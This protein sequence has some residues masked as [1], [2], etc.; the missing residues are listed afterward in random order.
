M[1]MFIRIF[2][3]CDLGVPGEYHGNNPEMSKLVHKAV[4]EKNK[5]AYAVYQEYLA[6]RPVNVHFLLLLS[7]ACARI[8][9]VMAE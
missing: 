3:P 5:D 8:I 2:F 6:H 4:R 1:L 9:S 7:F